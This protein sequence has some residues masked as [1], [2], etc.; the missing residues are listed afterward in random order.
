MRNQLDRWN[1]R[2]ISV[3]ERER[4]GKNVKIDIEKRDKSF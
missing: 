3:K 1:K 4:R 2:E